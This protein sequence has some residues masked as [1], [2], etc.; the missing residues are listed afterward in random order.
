MHEYETPIILQI[1][2]C[3]RQTRSKI[4]GF[5]TIAPS[6]LKSKSFTEETPKELSELEIYEVVDNFVKAIERTK[7][8]GFDGV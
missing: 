4:T 8:A 2:H 1:D 6:A 3:G 5:P 7:K